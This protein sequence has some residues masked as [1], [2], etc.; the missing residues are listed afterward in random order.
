MMMSARGNKPHQISTT[1]SDQEVTPESKIDSSTAFQQQSK[2]N[3]SDQKKVMTHSNSN[4]V[5]STY[6]TN[7]ST[8][9]IHVMHQ[10]QQQ[11][12]RHPTSRTH[13]HH[14]LHVRPSLL[15]D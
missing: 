6:V 13:H 15:F 7:T 10:V 4:I 9:V 2:R 11:P 5:W 3:T 12:V 1:I 14:H 8:A